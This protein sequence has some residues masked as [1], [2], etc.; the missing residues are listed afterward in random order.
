MKK[1]TE[2]VTKEFYV[3]TKEEAEYLHKFLG[4]FSDSEVANILGVKVESLLDGDNDSLHY[5]LWQQ[6]DDEFGEE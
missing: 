2:T 1:I 5:K 6:L 3:I 4:E